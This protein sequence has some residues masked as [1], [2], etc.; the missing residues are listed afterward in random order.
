MFKDNYTK[1]RIIQPFLEE[2]LS[3]SNISISQNI[4]LRTLQ[5]WCKNYRVQGLAGL[6]HQQR[7]DKNKYRNISQKL[8][9]FIEGIALKTP[10]LSVAAVCSKTNGSVA[11]VAG[12]L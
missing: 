9:H 11:S 1:F 6:E 5:R 10:K 3:L 7:S 12:D 4:P 8:L 2:G